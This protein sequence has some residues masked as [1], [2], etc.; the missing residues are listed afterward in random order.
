[1]LGVILELILAKAT[2]YAA[3][4]LLSIF[5]L[6][7]TR[8]P[9]K[10]DALNLLPK[11]IKQTDLKLQWHSQGRAKGGNAPPFSQQQKDKKKRVKLLLSRKL[12]VLM[13]PYYTNRCFSY[14]NAAKDCRTADYMLFD[15]LS[16]QKFHFTTSSVCSWSSEV[17]C[18]KG[19]A[20][21]LKVDHSYAIIIAT[22]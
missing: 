6:A 2:I 18:K 21:L 1:M 16:Q 9:H 15:I 10:K 4:K 3:K 13:T 14:L 20:W 22:S 17:N 19:W 12:Y 5:Y 7:Y 8:H 11:V